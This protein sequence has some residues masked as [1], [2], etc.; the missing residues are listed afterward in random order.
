MTGVVFVR[1]VIATGLVFAASPWME[2]MGVYNMF[3]VLSCISTAIA[4]TCIPM[5][6]WGRKFRVQLA[7]KYDYFINQQ[8]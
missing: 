2:G 7:G 8:Y 3:V 6:I 1:N 4:L 5:V